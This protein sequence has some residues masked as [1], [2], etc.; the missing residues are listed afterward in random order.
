M[1]EVLEI[2]TGLQKIVFVHGSLNDARIAFQ[3]QLDLADR[4][5]LVLP[6]RRGYGKS[7]SNGPVDPDIDA[8]DI[9]PLLG[10]GAHLVGTSMGGVVASRA[11]ALMP[12]SVLS[13][14]L[15]EPPAFPNAMDVPAVAEVAAAMKKHWDIAD[16]SDKVGFL[17][18]FSKALRSN[19]ARPSVLTPELDQAV[20][21][22]MTEAPWSTLIPSAAI[23][24]APFPKLL[25]SA[26]WSEA[27]SAICDRLATQWRGL[28]RT[29]P[30]AGHAVQRL[31]EPFNIFLESFLRSKSVQTDRPTKLNLSVDKG[32][33][34]D[35]LGV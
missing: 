13:L 26:D 1:L 18:G 21:R 16:K 28:R 22:L 8:Q 6:N 32:G 2:G 10:H 4:W 17:S 33:K 3:A 25:I 24:A 34:N 27:F 12:K 15:I 7:P 9:V 29:F 14:T 30:G 5:R 35:D 11:A 20:N 19:A 23:A 31:G